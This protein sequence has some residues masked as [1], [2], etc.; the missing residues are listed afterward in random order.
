MKTRLNTISGQV[1]GTFNNDTFLD[2]DP[3]KYQQTLDTLYSTY[4]TKTLPNPN[5][6]PSAQSK[7]TVVPSYIKVKVITYSSSMV[8]KTRQI[9]LK[10]QLLKN[11][12]LQLQLLKQ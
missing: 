2:T 12:I 5:P 1:D 3:P 8:T 4:S 11:M 6:F 10:M 9:L 7:P